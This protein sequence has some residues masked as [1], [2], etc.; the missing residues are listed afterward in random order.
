MTHSIQVS[1]RLFNTLPLASWPLW[2][3]GR[4]PCHR[5]G[6]LTLLC[7]FA[8]PRTWPPS[9][10]C[11]VE[12]PQLPGGGGVEVVSPKGPLTISSQSAIIWPDVV[13]YASQAIPKAIPEAIPEGNPP[14]LPQSVCSSGPLPDRGHP[15]ASQRRPF[16]P[17][18]TGHTI[19]FFCSD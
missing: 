15:A 12:C 5:R 8:H 14:I 13:A 3:V 4:L 1:L 18:A 11:R 6:G 16:R 17:P 7:D 19:D 9:F 2:E 10:N